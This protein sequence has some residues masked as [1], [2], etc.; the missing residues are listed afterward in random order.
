MKLEIKMP[1]YATASLVS[2][3]LFTFIGL[4]FFSQ[5]IIVPILYATIVAIVLGPVIRF[6]VRKG[7]NRVLAITLTLFAVI[8]ITISCAALLSSQMLQFAKSFPKL[9]EKLHLMIDESSVWVSSHF[10]ISPYNINAWLVKKN[11]EIANGASTAIAQTIIN[12]GSLLVAVVLCFVYVFMILYY[13]PLLLEFLQIVF[14]SNKQTDINE[15]LTETRNIIRGYLTGLLL[16]AAIVAAL[17]STV[18]LVLGIEY[19]ILLGVVSAI[20][21]MIPF[22]GGILAVSL[23]MLIAITT[24][25]AS[26]SLLVLVGYL[27]IQFIDN[28]FIIPKVVASRVKLNALVSVAV[29]LIGG[30]IWGIAGM[31][32]SIPLTAIVKLIFDR[33]DVL[34]PWGYLLGDTMPPVVNLKYNLWK[35]KLH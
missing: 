31:F 30:A 25:S 26:Y 3:G 32:L 9:I 19:A 2:I 22:L 6:F 7:M 29:V 5:K 17:N 12:T 14:K 21:N 33:V 8:I 13:Q 4:L 15:I 16:E 34:K 27:I 18:L 11:D 35:K 1:F 10:H 24:K 28:H 23:P 20:L